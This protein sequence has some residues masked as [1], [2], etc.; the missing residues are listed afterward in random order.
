[1]L[2]PSRRGFL[3]MLGL[4]ALAPVL[5]IPNPTVHTVYPVHQLTVPITWSKDPG[6]MFDIEASKIALIKQMMERALDQF[7]HQWRTSALP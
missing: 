4:A 3:R 1:M 6:T 5:P 2:R 7:D